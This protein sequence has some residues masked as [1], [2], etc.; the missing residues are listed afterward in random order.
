MSTDFC[1]QFLLIHAQ[2]SPEGTWGG[3][4]SGWVC[5]TYVHPIT[6]LYVLAAEMSGEGK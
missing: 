6:G 1:R 2:T 3:E 4:A 5:G